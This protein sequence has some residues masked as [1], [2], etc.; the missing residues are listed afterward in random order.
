MPDYSTKTPKEKPVQV[1]GIVQDTKYRNLRDQPPRMIYLPY[2][3]ERLLPW[4]YFVV[5]ARNVSIA[6]ASLR[7]ILR[8]LAPDAI[9]YQPVTMKQLVDGSAGRERLLTTL[10]NFFAALALLLMTVGLYGLLSYSVVL[11][12]K[13]IGI[14][15]AL[16]ASRAQVVRMVL[17]QTMWLVVPGLLLG[18]VASVAMTRLLAS[19]LYGAGPLDPF[20]FAVSLALLL[21]AAAL[22]SWMPARRAASIDPMQALRAE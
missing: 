6:V 19:L 21:G 18:A 14:R 17:R 13:E 20:S 9:L 11:R 22:A 3:Q 7:D 8:E 15:M 2:R 1:V 10:A 16:G 5:K 4:S 12:K